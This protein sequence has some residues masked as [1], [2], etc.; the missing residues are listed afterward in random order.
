[1]IPRRN[2]IYKKLSMKRSVLDSAE[3][4]QEIPILSTRS[5]FGRQ[6]FK[7][8]VNMFKAIQKVVSKIKI[9]NNMMNTDFS[10]VQKN[11]FALVQGIIA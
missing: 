2:S 3:E 9:T 11:N 1:M 5:T 8:D 10:K 6:G 4:E 7:A